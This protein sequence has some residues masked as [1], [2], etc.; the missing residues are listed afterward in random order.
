MPL[1]RIRIESFRCLTEVELALHPRK[2]YIF[3]PNGAGKTSLLEAIYLLGRGWSFRTRHSR[4]L[5][6]HG[7]QGFSVY[8]ELEAGGSTHRLGVGRGP[9]GL[10][11]R[12]DGEPAPG[13]AVLAQLLPV[14]VIEP[15]I[16]GLIEGG[17][18]D[19]RRFV[20]WGV[21][22]VEQGYLEAWRRYRRVLGQRNAAL[23]AGHG[24]FS[25]NAGLIE[26]ATAVD[27]ARTRYVGELALA[28]RG[29][30]ESLLG[31]ALEIRYR[32]GWK[33]GMAFP[34]ALE[35][36]ADRD[37][38]LGATQ[39]GPHRADL[40][41]SLDARGV[42]EEVSRGQQKLVAASLILAQI[43]VFAG[44]RGDGGVLLV[45]DPAAE[46]DDRALGGLMSVLD[47]LPAQQVMTSLS[48]RA[49]PAQPGYPVFHVEPGG[50][51]SML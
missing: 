16:H 25:W 38:A 42:R 14:H 31:H 32:S 35:A 47:E 27:A 51:L 12:L 5:I 19:R 28:L 37:R 40:L 2:N 39:V 41:V 3:G 7:Q 50:A 45:D 34:E 49:L 44:D 46:L 6:Q 43:R 8:G 48:E 10:E 13:M 4:R 33:A 21:F 9:R 15:N 17:P 36:S 24:A 23:K 11:L 30:G 1:N 18:K 20:D 26:A 22:H 29:L